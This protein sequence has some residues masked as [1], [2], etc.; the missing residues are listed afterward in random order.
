MGRAL[1]AAGFAALATP[2]H[3]FER[4]VHQGGLVSRALLRLSSLGHPFPLDLRGGAEESSSDAG[5]ARLVPEATLAPGERSAGFSI[6][7]GV[8]D[9]R[10]ASMADAVKSAR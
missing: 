7:M 2:S 3:C 5:D 9:V 1:L 4:S 6:A 8:D 10:H